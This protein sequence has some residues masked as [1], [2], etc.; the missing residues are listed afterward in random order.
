M[1]KTDICR[2]LLLWS[3]RLG[4]VA[5]YL[6]VATTC[7]SRP[8]GESSL[9]RS[10]AAGSIHST[11]P[12][13]RVLPPNEQHFA[14]HQRRWAWSGPGTRSFRWQ[15]PPAAGRLILPCATPSGVTVVI[16]DLG[17]GFIARRGPFAE[18]WHDLS[19]DLPAAAR[20]RDLHLS[21]EGCPD[22][23]V[24]PQACAWGNARFVVE[25]KKTKDLNLLFILVDTL[26]FDALGAYGSHNATP[27]ID[28]LAHEGILFEKMYAQ[29]SW[30][31][32][33]VSS[34]VTGLWPSES[35][36]WTGPIRSVSPAATPI[37]E[38]LRQSGFTTGAFVANPVLEDRY[39]GRGFDSWW[40]SPPENS[41]FTPASE[42]ASRAISWL[43]THQTD[44]FFLYLHL[45]D[46]HDPYAPPER[47]GGDDPS[48]W[49][50]QP[51]PAYLGQVPMPSATEVDGWHALYE[52]EVAYVDRE[53]GRVLATLEP[54]VRART[55]V[56]V[57]SDHGEEFLEHGFLKHGL[58]LFE[59]VIRVP[60][61]ISSP[62]ILPAGFRIHEVAR[63]VDALPTLLD[64]LS[65]K[66]EPQLE[67]S[68]A[69]VSLAAAIRREKPMPALVAMGET[70][71]QGP[72]RWYANDGKRKV[73]LFNKGFRMPGEMPV[74]EFPGRWVAENTPSA[75][76]YSFTDDQPWDQIKE[77]PSDDDFVWARTLAAQYAAGRSGGLWAV[78][79]GQGTGSRLGL[80][81]S[82]RPLF[83]LQ[84]S[85]IFWP[86][87][88]HFVTRSDGLYIDILDDGV[89]RALL[90]SDMSDARFQTVQLSALDS[91]LA[92]MRKKPTSEPAPGIYW[93]KE[94]VS[95]SSP[96]ADAE[97]KETLSRLRALG[98]VK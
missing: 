71:A 87:T 14:D 48:L 39:Y 9:A 83:A 45:M 30:T 35:P 58:T 32:P 11:E 79:R 4:A 15:L 77:P 89:P 8:P 20:E 68:W 13:T 42:V 1:C 51:D 33:S 44:R 84:I 80:L 96:E 55:I 54:E 94:S 73:I 93:W 19:L 37:A 85:P 61:I 23:T 95:T 52:E 10:L 43:G 59:E 57:T 64:L 78:V 26:R 91:G 27:I 3:C 29:S 76:S 69:G 72:L 25:S 82:S 7:S 62:G 36:G 16:E 70:F 18:G 66:A 88:D 90:V 12:A 65:V 67:N 41:V 75:A 53:I 6:V 47:R 40:G 34:L 21:F 22:E 56:V 2:R 24:D 74:L 86:E 60:F 38:V 81:L 28:S 63:L 46:P 98:Y 17:A 92:F 50:G 49:P 5:L 31:L 97:A